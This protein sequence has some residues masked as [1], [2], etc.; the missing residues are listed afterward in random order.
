MDTSLK[1]N[2]IKFYQKFITHEK[3]IIRVVANSMV[4]NRNTTMGSNASQLLHEAKQLGVIKSNSKIL[5]INVALYKKL[6]IYEPTSEDDLPKIPIMIELLRVCGNELYIDDEQFSND[7]ISMT[8][9]DLA[10]N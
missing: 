7:E 10:A 4:T 2:M 9:K 1:A 3:Q 8:I 6:K 5:D